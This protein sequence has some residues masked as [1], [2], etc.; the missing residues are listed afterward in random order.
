MNALEPDSDWRITVQVHNK[1]IGINCGEGSQRIKWLA[2]VA[3]GELLI[4]SEDDTCL[5]IGLFNVL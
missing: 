5:M 3:I 2:Q 4:F 1:S